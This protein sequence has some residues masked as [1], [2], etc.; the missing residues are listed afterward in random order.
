MA[1]LEVKGLTKAFGGLFA[2]NS[3]DFEVDEGAI[4]AIIGPNGAGKTTLFNLINGVFPPTS[5]EIIFAN[6]RLNKIKPYRR[7]IL[8]IGRTFQIAE[9]FGLMSA[10]EN[11]MV[12]C[13]S[14]TKREFLTNAFCLP[15]AKKEES[16]IR[17]K[18]ERI[19]DFL[20]LRAEADVP[21]STLPYGKQRLVSIGRA[22]A[23]EPKLLL[24]DEPAAG[25]NEFETARLAEILYDI[26]EMGITVVLVEHH[27][28]LV[29]N[30]SEE[31]IVLNYGRKIMEGTPDEVKSDG[32]VIEAYLGQS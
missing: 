29:M 23:T 15:A 13:H 18:S 19:L 10:L 16:L 14:R 3:L 4:K 12:G 25:L 7:C 5:G 11:I 8:G 28:G 1:I 26:R 17:E 6:I 22:M 21:A 2:I 32:R 24:L 30:V 27:M 31:I 20:G 9:S